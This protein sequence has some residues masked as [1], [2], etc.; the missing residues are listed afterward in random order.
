MG[1]RGARRG[2]GGAP[3]YAPPRRKTSAEIISEARAALYGDMSGASSSAGSGGALRPLR[4]RRPFTPR[5]P[6]RVLFGERARRDPR[7]P[8]AFDEQSVKQRRQRRAPRCVLAARSHRENHS[9][10]C[11]E[12]EFGGIL[13]RPVRSN[14]CKDVLYPVIY[15]LK[16]LSLSESNEDARVAGLEEEIDHEIHNIRKKATRQPA[17]QTAERAGEGWGA[18]PKLPHLS[19]KSKPL[20]RRNT[21]G[22]TTPDGS[23]NDV[24]LTN[25]I[26]ITHPLGSESGDG[27]DF[28]T[29]LNSKSLSPDPGIRR[30]HFATTKSQSYDVGGGY[31]L[32]S[33]PVKQLSVQLPNTSTS[34]DPENMT[35]L[36]LAEALSQ[37]S[38]DVERTVQLM[39]ALQNCLEKS[40]P[41]TSLRDMVLRSFYTHIDSDDERVLVAI[42]RAMLTMRVTGAHLAAACKLVFKIA[43][44]DKN[45]YFFRNTNLLELLVEGCGRA[46]PL[47]E[48]ECCVYGAGALRFL[49]LEPR[50]CTL[51]HRAGALHLAALHLK[52]LN[53]A[54]AENPRGVSEQSTHALYQLTGALRNLASGER[55]A[56]AFVSS[57][58]LG[59]LL[60]ALAHHT[61]RAV[62][63]NVARCLS[64]L[65]ANESC[66]L[67]L[68]GAPSSAGALL[69]A[70]AACAARAPL[71]V[72]L[73]YVLGNMA[74]A[75]DQA[76]LNIY[77]EEGGVDVLLTILE[78][79]TKRNNDHEVRDSESD[80]DMHLVG[81]DMGGSDG[82]NEDVLI[83]TV[84]VV[85]NLCLTERAGRG[86][87]AAHAERT[88]RALLGCLELAEKAHEPMVSRLVANLCLTERA[89][90]GLC[91][92]HAERTVR[93]LLG[94]LELAEKPHEPM[95][96]QSE[97][98]TMDRR[99]ELATAA[100]ATL[101]NVTFYREPP[102]P[103][104][105]LAEP[106]DD[107]CKATCRWLGGGGGANAACE[108]VRALG[109]LSRSQRAA[110]LIVLEGVLDALPAFLHHEEAS[111]RCAAAGVLV[112]VCGAGCSAR[113]AGQAAARALPAAAAARDAPQAALLARALWNAY[114]HC[115]LAP[116][117]TKQAAAALAAFIDDE[118]VFAACEAPAAGERRASDP[119]IKHHVKF[120]LDNNNYS[121]KEF[122]RP[123]FVK[124]HSVE[125]EL[126]LEGCSEED[127]D[128]ALSGEDLGFEEGD[129]LVEDGCECGP[130]RR[131][132]AWEELV[133]VAIPLLEKLKP[134]RSD[135]SVGTD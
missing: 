32:G 110:Q 12:N 3:F 84:R 135:A 64:V 109:N 58:A 1:E 102:A 87:C 65:S 71:A 92:A 129:M 36:E 79:Y 112:N 42:A 80:P 37:R 15:S 96:N 120:D 62:L 104:D 2:P 68:C 115:P 100:L 56:R 50:L 128:H 86:L 28:S 107:V 43:R 38:R 20:H 89:G 57:G 130:C 105:P 23:K 98:G 55:A 49:A 132:A 123:M 27:D 125:H 90:R 8:S 10:Y 5:E 19:G 101:N 73:A 127:S 59:E 91:A 35:V 118:S 21:T 93:A 9:A 66:C 7:P 131:L 121:N 14:Y 95:E 83:K 106:L 76:R 46:D 70:L 133:G 45:D 51:A 6:Q 111:V 54:K 34:E 33:I 78:S 40:M 63:T 4:T 117:S 17:H 113:A 119:Q 67:W 103:P 18:F 53:N 124:A 134:P 75:T 41:A 22:Q 99:E 48:G 44:N 122:Q 69:R 77:N 52:I 11:L 85:A 31:P 126:H 24:D 108:A 13:A 39:E 30:K 47:S 74:A 114:A 26:S 81:T 61:D 16:Y 116:A 82:S 88:V 72:R 94:C 29:E 25:M 97:E 60:A